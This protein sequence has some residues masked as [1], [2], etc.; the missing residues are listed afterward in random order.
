MSETSHGSSF[1]ERWH[2]LRPDL[3][4]D[5]AAR[6]LRR[7]PDLGS[8]GRARLCDLAQD[9][10]RTLPEEHTAPASVEAGRLRLAR[11]LL[12]RELSEVARPPCRTAVAEG[13]ASC[14]EE[15]LQ[16]SPEACLDALHHL[17][18][19][20]QPLQE[21]EEPTGDMAQGKQAARR[22]RA[23]AHHLRHRLERKLGAG[24]VGAEAPLEEL[25]AWLEA[26]PDHPATWGDEAWQDVRECGWD[27]APL[28]SRLEE[29]LTRVRRE[30]DKRAEQVRQRYLG[31]RGDSSPA[32]PWVL[33]QWALD[34]ARPE[35]WAW[36]HQSLLDQARRLL[37]QM[38]L[39][40]TAPTV[41]LRPGCQPSWPEAAPSRDGLLVGLGDLAALDGGALALHM[42]WASHVLPPL[43]VVREGVPGRA[44]ALQQV[45]R[46]V[47][48]PASSVIAA[49][50]RPADLECWARWSVE[51]MLNHGW[52]AGESRVRLML[53]RLEEWDLLLARADLELR[54]GI[55]PADDVRQRL[56][57][58]G[59]VP[60][61]MAERAWLQVLERPGQA[62]QAC[63]RLL[64]LREAGRRW[65]RNHREAGTADWFHLVARCA[66]LP[67]AWLKEHLATQPA[68]GRNWRPL[69]PALVRPIAPRGDGLLTEMEERLAALGR[70]RRE[71][72]EA[73]REFDSQAPP[74]AATQ[75][76]EAESGG[77]D[78]ASA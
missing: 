72:I 21:G 58:E 53:A 44:W 19:F 63:A 20:L 46:E 33:E 66:A 61:H 55:R 12:R 67:G 32:L 4:T 54:L 23:L 2:W 47:A 77:D 7:W 60:A 10:L 41:F 69:P 74:P 50:L 27:M 51:W 57:R 42:A 25:A 30:L 76:V 31:G 78:E 29:E 59:V 73:G 56:M 75:A 71:D 48:D 40:C 9:A 16:R 22:L 1:A 26:L 15:L 11:H 65:R 38:G 45:G 70:I 39:D 37:A 68:E 43:V 13:V 14:V 6:E 18:E 5:P 17:P 35:Q 8:A 52:Q 28:L 62:A 34:P 49:L 3:V 36:L 64:L 24:A